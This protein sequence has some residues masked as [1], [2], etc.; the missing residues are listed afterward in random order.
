MFVRHGIVPPVVRIN[1]HVL[2]ETSRSLN[3]SLCDLK[4][5]GGAG[6]F[7]RNTC[8]KVPKRWV[9]VFRNFRKLPMV[10][11]CHKKE[12]GGTPSNILK[13]HGTF[14]VIIMLKFVS[15][16]RYTVKKSMKQNK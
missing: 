12:R 1:Y 9:G 4:G 8:L 10:L 16:I 7:L 3:L 14:L 5:M 2:K 6:T 11:F 13:Y 15:N